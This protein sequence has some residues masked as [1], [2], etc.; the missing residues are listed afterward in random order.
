MEVL[1]TF[2]KII[3]NTEL[4]LSEKDFITIEDYLWKLEL[5]HTDEHV[6][7]ATDDKFVLRHPTL[8]FL[9]DRIMGEFYRL[10]D[11]HLKYENKFV[12]NTSWYTHSKPGQSAP[13]HNHSNCMFSGVFYVKVPEN[14]GDIEFDSHS[15]NTFQPR[16][17]EPNI[18]NSRSIK[19]KPSKG[20]LLF[21]DSNIYH[22]IKRNESDEIRVSIAFNLLPVGDLGYFDSHLKLNFD[23]SGF[24][25]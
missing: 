24:S 15:G 1:P 8:K 23:D 17:S 9:H 14:S 20:K 25:I 22:E 12:M 18:F 2:S 16:S 10:N 11:E 5:F 6:A 13:F 3:C 4:N 21:F 7:V 19:I